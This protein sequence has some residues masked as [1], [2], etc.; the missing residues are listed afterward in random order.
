MLNISYCS[1]ALTTVP[2][3]RGLGIASAISGGTWGRRSFMTV[4]DLIINCHED[5]HLH[6]CPSEVCT[7]QGTCMVLNI[8]EEGENLKRKLKTSQSGDYNCWRLSFD[9][10]DIMKDH[11]SFTRSCKTWQVNKVW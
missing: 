5:R 6:V 11:G 8:E 1:G 10:E 9:M 4:D 3:S 2:S 7:F